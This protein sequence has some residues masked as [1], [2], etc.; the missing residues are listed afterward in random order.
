M[1]F[2]TNLWYVLEVIFTGFTHWLFTESSPLVNE[3]DCFS[4]DLETGLSSKTDCKSNLV[5]TICEKDD[6]SS[7]NIGKR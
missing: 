5:Q 7:N 3:N 2:S 4:L 6:D 1:I